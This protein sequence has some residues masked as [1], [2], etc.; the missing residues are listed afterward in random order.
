MSDRIYLQKNDTLLVCGGSGGKSYLRTF[1][2]AGIMEGAGASSICYQA[3]HDQS[4]RGVLKEFYPSSGPAL[5]RRADGQLVESGPSAKTGAA[6]GS[7]HGDGNVKSDTFRDMIAAYIAPYEKLL[8]LRQST[9]DQDLSTFI[10]EFEI[11]YGCGA[12]GD[13]I[14]TVYVFTPR[15]AVETFDHVCDDIH[16]HPEDR[17]ESKLF[18]ALSSIRTLTLCVSSLHRAG[19]VD[20]DI[21]PANFGF[22]KRGG[23]TLTQAISL[24]DIN[25]FCPV[26]SDGP[27][28]ATP[29][30]SEPELTRQRVSV[31]TDIYSI[32]ATLF[33][34]IIVTDQAEENG[35]LYG[36]QSPA[37][38]TEMV[39]SSRLITASESNSHPKLRM[40][41]TRI[42]Q[43]SLSDR[44]RRYRTCEEL[45]QD[46]DKAMFYVLPP[47]MAKKSQAG[48]R[49]VLKD[50]EPVLDARAGRNSTL[51]IQYHLYAHPLY[52]AETWAGGPCSAVSESAGDSSSPSGDE[53]A[54]FS[55]LPSGNG[56]SWSDNL[57]EGMRALNLLVAGFGSYGTIFLDS[58]LSA[59]QMKD[60]LLNVTVLSDDPEMVR[61]YLQERPELEDFFCITYGKRPGHMAGSRFGSP[62]GSTSAGTEM[63][64]DCYGRIHF[65]L[66]GS[67]GAGRA[68]EAG[69]HL[70]AHLL[71]DLPPED[72]PEYIF[73]ALGDDGLSQNTARAFCQEACRLKIRPLITYVQEER[74]E[75]PEQVREARQLVPLYITEDVKKLPYSQEI[76]R[77]SFNTHLLWEKALNV[78]LK[79]VREVWQKPYYRNASTASVLNLKYKLYSIGI[80][81]DCVTPAK[82]AQLCHDYFE[83]GKHAHGRD[84]LIWTEHRRWVTDKLCKGWKSMPDLK[85]CLALGSTRDDRN[86]RHS[87]ILHSRPDHLLEEH[88]CKEGSIG[89]WDTASDQ[90]LAVLD[91]LDRMSVELH[92]LYAKQA[93]ET[94]RQNLL[95]GSLVM[96]IKALIEGS[97]KAM[98]A[99][100]DW[101]ACMDGIFKKDRSKAAL[102]RGL[103][104]NFLQSVRED[105]A[106]K[107][108]QKTSLLQAAEAL[109]TLFSP[110]TAA[111]EYVDFKAKDADIVDNIPF[112]LTYSADACMVIPYLTGQELSSDLLFQNVAAATVVNPARI[113]YLVLVR[114]PEDEEAVKESLPRLAAYLDRKHLQAE[115]DFVILRAG[116][117]GRQDRT[118]IPRK[119]EDTARPE[120]EL[121]QEE[122]SFSGKLKKA[123]RGRVRQV[124]E[125]TVRKDSDIPAALKRSLKRTA[126]SGTVFTLE[127]NR[128]ELSAMLESSGAFDQVPAY[129]FDSK[130][131]TFKGVGTRDCVYRYISKRPY[132]T[133]S[134]LL[135]LGQDP[136]SRRTQIQ[137]YGDFRELWDRYRKDPAAWKALCG[138][139]AGHSDG[140][141]VL[142]FF[143]KTSEVLSERYVWLLPD[144]CEKSAGKILI[145]LK[146]H[147][148]VRGESSLYYYTADCCRLVLYG[149]KSHKEAYESLFSDPCRL[150]DADF[151]E[152]VFD[153]DSHTLK[154]RFDSLREEG[155]RIGGENA[156]AILDLLNFFEEKRYLI[157]LNVDKLPQET[158]KMQISGPEREDMS[159]QKA[160]VSLTYASRAVKHFLENAERMPEIYVCHR[161]REM[162]LFDDVE[163]GFTVSRDDS[164]TV[165]GK[166]CLIL[167]KG[168]T[169]TF[170]MCSSSPETDQDICRQLTSLKDR[171][172]I[173]SRAV[174]IAQTGDG[175]FLPPSPDVL[176]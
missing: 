125:I 92:R 122:D 24:F 151:I 73:I 40:L 69:P 32:G 14:G 75:T 91:P 104:E 65:L 161:I 46:L 53:P 49:W 33:T 52:E 138:M 78:D 99:F 96:G 59:G 64:D 77:M 159:A 130:K 62:F 147:G 118:G 31:Q 7:F 43:K 109:D 136:P 57:P 140:H 131:M 12:D 134:D 98:A 157:S 166:T 123:G 146:E 63:P 13:P 48:Q 19:I 167:T 133:V 50:V 4:S 129:T 150:F 66:T 112:I 25:S 51:A 79:N 149:A 158:D 10:P 55:G 5:V 175:D 154:I 106:L 132:L 100:E 35:F 155:I 44:R 101:Y 135:S 163:G 82:A 90:E 45:L 127:K 152:P 88:F 81:L 139:L 103:K 86:R 23:E 94:R 110:L 93:E 29:G 30:Y 115:L 128:S 144:S 107:K 80:D 168:F 68:S 6:S 153:L 70:A 11:Y 114:S 89:K 27:V 8:A 28:L 26:W 116:G 16:R 76:G 9:S 119:A 111:M 126:S 56:S 120:E 85:D 83:G 37:S 173:N 160:T 172:G 21:K 165:T 41:L 121:C 145:S 137:F 141:D 72:R 164:G 95:H 113:I 39:A 87:C 1:H 117:E 3:W 15:P 105:P 42:L 97:P 142:A 171:L 34:A 71:H 108:A 176:L 84:L 124:R 2:I 170:A 47:D 60:R 22:V 54:G 17:P 58:A 67:S 143:P 169:S 74:P 36:G 18:L 148:I 156:E 162:G 174:L 20:C 102:Y 61:A 38:L